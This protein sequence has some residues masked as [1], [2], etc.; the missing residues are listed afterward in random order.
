MREFGI[1][2]ALDQRMK[3]WILEVN[4]RPDMTIFNELKNKKFYC[5]MVRYAKAYGRI[6]KKPNMQR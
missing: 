5:K 6:G 3:P 4:T 1:D 2:V